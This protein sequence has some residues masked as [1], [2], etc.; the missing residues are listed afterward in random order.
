MATATKDSKV[1]VIG[2]RRSQLALAQAYLVRDA[3]AKKYPEN[4]FKIEAMATTGDRIL[5]VALSKIGEK[6]LFTKE[7]E[8]ALDDGRVDFVVH[9]LKDL[10]TVLEPGMEI[11]AILDRETPNDALVLAERTDKSYTLDTLPKGSVI[12]T[13]SLRRTAQIKRRRP[14]LEIKSV[15]GNIHTRI[16]KLDDPENGVDALVLAAAGL[17]RVDLGGRINQYLDDAMLYAVSQGALAIECRANDARVKDLLKALDHLET[18]IVCTAERAMMRELEGGCSVPI[19]VKTTFKGDTLTLDGLV[20]S[21]DG[22]QV[23]ECKDQ[24]TV[25]LA[26]SMESKEA[27][28]KELGV[29]VAQ[30]LLSKGAD[31]ILKEISESN[32]KP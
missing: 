2:T 32:K 4:E 24:T 8:L 26:A 31:V 10:P 9:S 7:L 23:A 20:A 29:R 17:I 27:V 16:S 25:D 11:G 1:F 5:D 22:K 14:D 15:R 18:R 21:L 19:G 3:L 13:S 12:G 28:A 6:S 30:K